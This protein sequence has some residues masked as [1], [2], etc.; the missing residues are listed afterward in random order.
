MNYDDTPFAPPLPLADHGDAVPAAPWLAAQSACAVS[1]A[2]AALAVGRLDA[3]IAGMERVAR[4]GAIRRIA[5]I[6][7]EAML[8]AQGTPVRR[9]EVGRDV[10][11]ARADT[12]LTAMH[13]AR[14]ALRRLEGRGQLDDPRGFL[15]LRKSDVAILAEPMALRPAG[16]EFDEASDEFARKL[17]QFSGLHPLARAPVSR[18]LWRIAELSPID[19][20][21]EAAVWTGRSMAACCEALSFVPLGRHGRRIWNDHGTPADRLARHLQAVTDGATDARAELLRVQAWAE[22]A[23]QRTARIKGSNPARV[24]AALAAQPLMTTAMVEQHAGIS[25][26]TAERL[27][28]RFH[29]MGLVRELTGTRRFR[30]WTAAA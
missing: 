27:L 23:K 11:E 13:L 19:D 3:L 24:I 28:G 12:D 5:M 9:E 2:A 20:L 15:G 21:T 1:L 8:W 7:V 30:L 17:E 22:E 4:N 16:E 26:D 25:R 29:A 14:W 18:I 6:E 10:M